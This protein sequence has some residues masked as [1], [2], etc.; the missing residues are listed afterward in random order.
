MFA[1]LHTHTEYS[2]LDGLSKIPALVDRARGLGQ[3]S[4]AITDHGNLYGAV[5]FYQACESEG[6]R[7]ILGMEAYVAPG[8]RTDRSDGREAASNSFHLVLL[9]Q[10]QVGWRNLIQLSTRGHLEG[11]YY[12]P[13]I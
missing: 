9:A 12:R 7:P 5:E 8:I 2:E 13:R 1:H 3:D 4:L 6:L 10:N 11:F